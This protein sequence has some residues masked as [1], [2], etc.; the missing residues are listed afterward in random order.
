MAGQPKGERSKQEQEAQKL[1]LQYQELS[2]EAKAGGAG[3]SLLAKIE[4]IKNPA[5]ILAP[6]LAPKAPS[7][8]DQEAKKREEEEANKREAEEPKK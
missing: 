8:A 7:K 1:W 5:P 4:A 3:L 2:P 6:I